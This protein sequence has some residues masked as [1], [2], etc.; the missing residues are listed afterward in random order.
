M[1]KEK[2]ERNFLWMIVGLG[3]MVLCYVLVWCVTSDWGK[4]NVNRMKFAYGVEAGGNGSY[5]GSYL[6]YAPDTATQENPGQLILLIHGGTS[7]CF[8]LKNYAMELARRGYVVVTPDLPTTGYS[9]S[10]G[11]AGANAL[12]K[13]NDVF[14]TALEKHLESYDF[15]KE[16]FCVIGFS[17]GS[18]TARTMIT[19]FPEKYISYA[20]VTNYKNQEQKAGADL[21]IPYWGIQPYG[22][23]D[24]TYAK[25]GARPR[26]NA[27][28]NGYT[29]TI[30]VNGITCYCY[31]TNHGYVHVLIPDSTEMVSN[32]IRLQE[33]VVPSGIDHGLKS[34]QLVFWWAEIFA[35]IGLVAM[36]VFIVSFIGLLLETNF[37][38]SVKHEDCPILAVAPSTRKEKLI[39][40]G[41]GVAEFAVFVFL[42]K[43]MGGKVVF[44]TTKFHPIWINNL[45]PYLLV[46]AAW[47]I[48]KFV[49][50]HFKCKKNGE[51]NL[52]NYGFAWNGDIKY[53]LANIGKSFILALFSVLIVFVVAEYMNFNLGVNFQFMVF[54]M[55][56]LTLKK[57]A[58][59]P[60]YIICYIII[61]IGAHLM[62]YSMRT[63]DCTVSSK[64]T[65]WDALKGAFITIAPILLWC[66]YNYLVWKE[67]II[68]GK[69]DTVA[70]RLY[71]YVLI[72]M[73]IG[74]LH[75]FIYKKTKNVWPGIF[76]CA[77]MIT[78]M[79]CS[80]YPLSASYFV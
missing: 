23:S 24:Y 4:I 76:T 53:N 16:D 30:D 40:V 5:E 58:A 68:S 37:F 11:E 50:W 75:A 10:V 6:L 18:T 51:G 14:L 71:G 63:K 32:A 33:M 66:I 57:A 19:L 26:A 67:V 38:S 39:K 56:A 12:G 60:F 70:D 22:S 9:D 34:T 29:E 49:F 45:L 72:V 31:Y 47:Q 27:D 79:V 65:L 62:A 77:M 42:Y 59:T 20:N 21:G 15:V 8:A 28:Y 69:M 74:P 80:N 2:K 13:S 46:L 36:I 44:K 48:A 43:V 55:S 52:V 7:N 1:M 35:L 41:I 64:A 78:F 17:N 25:S 54:T 3:V 61:F 73:I